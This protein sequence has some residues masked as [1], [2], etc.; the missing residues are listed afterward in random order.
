MFFL[1][2]ATE[3]LDKGETVEVC[4]LDIRKAFDSVNHRFLLRKLRALGID[5]KA[6]HWIEEFLR[7]RSFRVRIGNSYSEEMGAPSGVP[8][9]SVLGPLLFLLY[10]NDLVDK[11]KQPCFVFADD[12]KVVSKN[13]RV[14]LYKDIEEV[15]KWALKWD[16]GLNQDKCSILTKVTDN[17]TATTEHGPFCIQTAGQVKDLGVLVTNDSKWS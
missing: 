16:L 4:Y 17:L 9:G 11:I 8:Q 15:V 6:L 5:N 3:S 7:E 12:V 14:G 10:I 1:D 13:S 2:G